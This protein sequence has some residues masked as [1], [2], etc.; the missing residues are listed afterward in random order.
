MRKSRRFALLAFI[1]AANSVAAHPVVIYPGVISWDRERLLVTLEVNSHALQ[2]AAVALAPGASPQELAEAL[3]RSLEVHTPPGEVLVPDEARWADSERVEI[4]VKVPDSPSALALRLR[5]DTDLAALHQQWQLQWTT[6]YSVPRLIRLT[7]GGNVE[8]IRRAAKT[9][10]YSTSLT[11]PLLKLEI[12]C[13]GPALPADSTDS[14]DLRVVVVEL[15][16]PCALLPVWTGVVVADS[17][18]ITAG[19]LAESEGPLATWLESHLA[20][21]GPEGGVRQLAIRGVQL[22]TVEDEVVPSFSNAPH[23]AFTSR[24]RITASSMLPSD[25]REM[26]LSW[27]GLNGLVKRLPA[28]FRVNDAFDHITDLTAS[29]SR[30]AVRISEDERVLFLSPT[31]RQ[32]GKKLEIPLCGEEAP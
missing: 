25:Q 22:V 3:A 29:N 19:G 9:R 14:P 2:H 16:V 13:P 31:H 26:V 21:G 11:E 23:S 1:A 30:I 18:V 32:V 5:S 28:A 4:D 12:R 8:I 27:D 20:I 10:T 15:D 17:P 24:V 6:E 7:T